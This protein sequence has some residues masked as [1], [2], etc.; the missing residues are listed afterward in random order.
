MCVFPRRGGEI[1]KEMRT[2]QKKKKQKKK[3]RGESNG[4]EGRKK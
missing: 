2:K 3:K 4:A 1:R